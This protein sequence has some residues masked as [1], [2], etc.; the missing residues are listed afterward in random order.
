MGDEEEQQ[1]KNSKAKKQLERAKAELKSLLQASVPGFFPAS[2]AAM[3]SM[4]GVLGKQQ[5]EVEVAHSI[6]TAGNTASSA[7]TEVDLDAE[8]KKKR[9]EQKKR[10]K[11]QGGGGSVGRAGQ[12]YGAGAA[13]VMGGRR[14]GL[15]VFAK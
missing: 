5:P 7:S 10:N 11:Q 14:R 1:Q 9:K 4:V 6:S 15:I 2:N 12:V 13:G 3:S 8:K